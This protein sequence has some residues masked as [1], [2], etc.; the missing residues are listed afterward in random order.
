MA[1][2][3]FLFDGAA[4]GFTRGQTVAGALWAAGIRSWRTS[5]VGAKPRG[6]FCGIGACFD[7][8]A[9]VDG[10]AGE[11]LCVTPAASGLRVSSTGGVGAAP[12]PAPMPIRSYDLIVV[13]G[14]PAGMAAAATAALGGV[15]V[16]LL[17]AAPALG[18]QFWRHRPGYATGRGQRDWATFTGLSSLVDE[19]VDHVP[20]ATVWFAGPG[21]TLHTDAGSYR[22]PRIVLA[23][24]AHDRVYPF[25]GW[26]LPGVITAGAAQAL[27][28]GSGVAA[29]RR[30]VVAGA[31]PFLLPVAAALAEAGV[32]VSGVFEAGDPRRYLAGASVGGLRGLVAKL[33]EAAGYA[34]RLA[35]LRVPYQVRRA[36]IAAHPNAD[37]VLSSV[38]V[39]ALDR[40]GAAV[41]GSARRIACDTLA[42]GFGF[43]ANLELALALGADVRLGVDGGL[44]VAV[45][46]DGR[47]STPGLYAAGEVTGIGGAALA[48]VEGQLAGAAAADDSGAGPALTGRDRTALRRRQ[49]R[50]RGFADLMHAAHAAPAGWPSWLD[51]STVV[52]RCEEVS[53][54]AVR[55]AVT[56]LGATDGRGVKLFAR[57]GMGWCQGRTCGPAVAA[58]TARACGRAVTVDDLRAFAQR[59]FSTPV[60]LG[61]L[62]RLD[63][64][65]EQ[66]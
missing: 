36:V 14:G 6:L 64:T 20:G 11:R 37:G 66:A 4:V 50:L 33:P 27:L 38:D 49:D 35:R 13:G 19:R 34:G 44:A 58:L 57:P 47:T 28:K 2:D 25:P 31:G 7:C 23:T 15:T 12:Q 10:R 60:R 16:A 40:G 55:A 53:A 54:S 56:E 9:T 46:D 45:D 51:P 62:A 1:R 63:G 59:P 21:F 61:D 41:P 32:R 39:A 26:D 43:T 42:V 65:L 5:R 29:G 18:G 24:G 3:T 48:V 30:V 17:D 52:C 8:L 22:A